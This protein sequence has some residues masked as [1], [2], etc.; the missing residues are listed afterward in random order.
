MGRGL[1][2]RQRL[3]L[4]ALRALEG[5]HG[6]CWFEPFDVIA[7]TL[8]IEP[9]PEMKRATHAERAVDAQRADLRR[10]AALGS[11]G[12]IEQLALFEHGQRQAEA[13]RGNGNERVRP[14][15][16][17]GKPRA[18]EGMNPSRALALLARRGLVQRRSHCGPGSLVALTEAGRAVR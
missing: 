17:R 11:P 14:N 10:M 9:T 1:G 3:I 8:D 18:G 12:H 4:K 13:A 16:L 6:A 2:N 7:A 5:E 15:L